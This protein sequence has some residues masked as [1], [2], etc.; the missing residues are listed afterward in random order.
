MAKKKTSE[1]AKTTLTDGQIDKLSVELLR[2]KKANIYQVVETMFPGGKLADADWERL[3]TLAGVFK[4]DECDEWTPT[5]DE[6]R[7]VAGV[8]EICGD[9][10]E[11]D[12]DTDE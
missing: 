7:N 8:C 11:I 10:M 6:H 1:S 5:T 3:R 2:R 12:A 4:C 9:E